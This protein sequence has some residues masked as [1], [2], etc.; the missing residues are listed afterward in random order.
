MGRRLLHFIFIL[1]VLFPVAHASADLIAHWKFDN[2]GNDEIGSLT[3]TLNNGATF[4]TDRKEGSHSLLCDGVDDHAHHTPPDGSATRAAFSTHTVTLWF[5]AD[6]VSGTQVIFDEGGSTNGLAIRIN[7][8]FLETAA[9]NS[10]VIFTTSTPFSSTDW[11]HVA[12]T[13]EDGL[14][15]LFVD[16]VEQASVTA[17]FTT[18]S[19][20]SNAAGIGA[21]RSQDAFDNTATGDYFGGLIDDVQIYSEALPLEEILDILAGRPKA[22]NP[23]PADGTLGV[24]TPLFSWTPGSFAVFHD[25]YLDTSP[26]LGPEDLIAPRWMAPVYWY[27]AGLEPGTTYYW[28]VDEIDPDGTVH[29]G[30]VWTFTYSPNEA[31]M[32]QPADGVP[33]VDPNTTLTW[34]AGLTGLSH[35]V[36]LGTDEAAVTDGADDVFKGN[37]YETSFVTGDLEAET[38]YYWRIDEVDTGGNKVTG[39]VWSFTTLPEIPITDPNFVVWWKADEGI[40][41]R[42]IDW[43]GHGNHGTF[44]GEPQ[45]V[46]GF[47][48]AALNFDGGT[49]SAVYYFNDV[50]W[51]AYTMAVWAKA[52]VLWQSN[53]S[54]ICATY[55][56]TAGGFQFSFDA[57]NNY[58]YH[59]DVDYIMGPASLGW[60]HLAVT[61]NGV[62]ATAYY[63]G[64]PVGTFVPAAD[65]LAWN[66]FAIGVNRAE[67]NW[68]DGSVDDFR[69]YN[70]ELSFEEIQLVMRIDPLRAWKPQPVDGAVTDVRTTLPLTWLAGDSASQH[71]VYLGTDKAAVAVAD[72]TDTSGIYRGR[73]G[74]TSYTPAEGIEWGRQYFWRVDEINTDG[75]VTT[76]GVWG[77]TVADYL[78]VDDFESYTNDIGRRV[79]EV[80]IDG[81]GFTQPD[82]GNL[83]NGTGSAVGHDVWSLD[84]PY[85]DGDIMETSDVFS[86]AQAMPLY[87]N[88]TALPYYSEAERTWTPP[89]DWT[90]NDV[91]TLVV[92]FKGAPV[93]FAETSPGSITISGAGADIW[94]TT[95]EFTFAHKPLTGDCT[96]IARID[97]LIDTN[98]AAKAGLMIRESLDPASRFAMAHMTGS[99]GFRFTTR[100][101]NGGS[102]AN[103]GGQAS[104]EQ[105]AAVE[106]LWMKLERTGNEFN[107]YYSTDPAVAGWTP[108]PS[109]PQ[110]VVMGGTIYVGLAVTSHSS[111]NPTTAEFSG[112]EITG[113]SGVWTFSEIGVDHFL[114]SAA[115]LY[116]TVEDTAGRSGS[117]LHPDGTDAVLSTEWRPWVVDLSEFVSAGVDLR[118]IRTMAIGVGAPA[119]PQ[120]DGSGMLLID[121]IRIM[122]GA[123][124]EPNDVP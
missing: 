103:D 63:N 66:K 104:A 79:F 56:T 121:D 27:A 109:N 105:N 69:V 21:R 88:N 36:Y 53:N 96:A 18:V 37:T 94:G 84:S 114:N 4:S 3:W 86:G 17:S 30:R 123:P 26:E 52:D 7:D 90:F 106:P 33:Y 14:L 5:K 68:F 39:E 119:N 67:D 75:S 19:A 89:Q 22:R 48:G 34:I 32:P 13:F 31:W 6:T 65:D 87:Y 72:A 77:F 20:H 23:E 57:A 46:E 35:D 115:N 97:S 70:R 71:D 110:T 41:S 15:K 83:G 81:I 25:I 78:I 1:V 61:Y 50:T 98:A 74:A 113:A 124:E 29:P 73:L 24:T 43:S 40:G 85:L 58:Q 2:N 59:A 91:N 120:P 54:S 93:G 100:L 108:S 107:A 117:V 112:V 47:D 16:G 116:V 8:G 95:D 28:K 51:S 55:A 122:Q 80:W 10:Q 76:G 11:T 45:W 101:T 82:P 44:N 64:D 60:V 118:T 62:N 12:V 102:A 38:T 9:Q 92:Y 99:N 111:G 49:Q 42:V